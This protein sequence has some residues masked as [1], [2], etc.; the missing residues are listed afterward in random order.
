MFLITMGHPNLLQFQQILVLHQAPIENS[1][2]FD[3]AQTHAI[4]SAPHRTATALES[5]VFQW[6]HSESNRLL[7]QLQWSNNH[8]FLALCVNIFSSAFPNSE[9]SAMGIQ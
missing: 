4:S 7:L 5:S 2:I 9:H 1:C 8:P 6:L 3:V